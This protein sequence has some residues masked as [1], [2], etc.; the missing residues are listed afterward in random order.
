MTLPNS[1]FTLHE[2]LSEKH[3]QN[4]ETFLLIVSIIR[5]FAA[6]KDWLEVY[7]DTANFATKK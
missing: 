5:F 7:F 6:K 1:T 4:K 3:K 2:L